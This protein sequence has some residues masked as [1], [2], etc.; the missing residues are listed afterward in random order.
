MICFHSLEDRRVKAF[1]RARSQG[2]ICPPDLPVC[3]C[4]RVAE[5]ALLAT[6]A[7]RPR[8]AE[9]DR[10]PRARSARLRALQRRGARA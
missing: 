5:A 7:L 8:Q 6:K 1:M 10:N 3:G 4:G 9:L 2:C